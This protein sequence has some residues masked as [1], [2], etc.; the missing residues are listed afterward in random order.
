MNYKYMTNKELIDLIIL[1]FKYSDKVVTVW[2]R[3]HKSIDFK[4]L[5]IEMNNARVGD[6]LP[7]EY[8]NTIKAFKYYTKNKLISFLIAIKKGR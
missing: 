3:R 1:R 2:E 5:E 7:K 4:A 8:Y 6:S